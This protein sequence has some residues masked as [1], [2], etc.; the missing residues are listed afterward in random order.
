MQSAGVKLVLPVL[1]RDRIVKP[2]KIE[3]GWCDKKGFFQWLVNTE[4]GKKW[5]IGR[6]YEYEGYV[7]DL[8]RDIANG[9][10]N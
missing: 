2:Y 3:D 6:D 5:D 1:A 9:K 8:N 10:F 7:K 4:T